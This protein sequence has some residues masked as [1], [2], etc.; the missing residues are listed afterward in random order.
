MKKKISNSAEVLAEMKSLLAAESMAELL[1]IMEEVVSFFGQF[2]NIH[3]VKKYMDEM[4]DELY[5]VKE[6]LTIEEAA[7]YTG[8]SVSHLYKLTSNR[9]IS[10]CKPGGKKNFLHRDDL[11]QFMAKN[12]I[13]AADECEH[14]ARALANKYLFE[15]P[16]V[17]NSRR[18]G[19]LC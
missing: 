10:F 6:F 3:E 13:P 8:L 16:E 19:R 9:R 2:K 12:R 11:N 15:N 5:M 4:K 1:V 7:K 14:D 18:G 17:G